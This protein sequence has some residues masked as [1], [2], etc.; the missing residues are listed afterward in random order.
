MKSLS[1]TPVTLNITTKAWLKMTS[2]V[3]Q[4]NKELAWH[5]YVKRIGNTFIWYDVTVY[6]QYTTAATVEPDEEEYAEW[7]ISKMTDDNF[8]ELR[9]HGHS[10]VN[11]TTSPSSVDMN[12]RYDMLKN[13][14]EDDFYIFLIINKRN[15]WTIE[16]YDY[17]TG[18]IYNEKDLNIVIGDMDEIESINNWAEAQIT[19]NIKEEIKKWNSRSYSTTSKAKNSSTPKT[20][21]QKKSTLSE[22]EPWE[23][24][25]YS[26]WYD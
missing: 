14:K 18:L 7:L 5:G 3:D 23:E 1:K 25:Y 13:L 10:H 19:E 15:E 26:H 6:P 12:Y 9:L 11:M 16:L 8:E 20:S 2:L 22:L 21:N 17:V 4:C 24:P